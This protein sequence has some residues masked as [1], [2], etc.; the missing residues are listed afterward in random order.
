M[1]REKHHKVKKHYKKKIAVILVNE[2]ADHKHIIYKHTIRNKSRK[3]V[4]Q[5]TR[6]ECKRQKM[7]NISFINLTTK[8][9]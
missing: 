7:N 2:Q 8:I 4:K 9:C 6:K 5:E 1:P 3:M